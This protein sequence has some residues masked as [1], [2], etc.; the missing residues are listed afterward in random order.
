MQITSYYHDVLYCV[1]LIYKKNIFMPE[2]P[3]VETIAKELQNSSILNKIIKQV[4]VR[5]ASTIHSPSVGEF[6]KNLEGLKIISVKRR[7]K[8]IVLELSEGYF[9]IIHLR[10]TGRFILS[11]LIASSK[12]EHVILYFEGCA[13]LRYHD[14][15]KFGRFSLVK[16]AADILEELGPEP[17]QNDF[18][19]Q[20]FISM[21]KNKKSELKPLLL[22]QK[23]LAGLGNIYVDEAL[24]RASLHPKRQANTLSPED[25][26]TLHAAIQFVLKRGLLSNGTTL[27][28][29]KTNYYRID[30]VKGEHQDALD[31]FRK[32]GEPC[33]RC[34]CSIERLL[35]AQR[36]THICP[37]CQK[38][39][40]S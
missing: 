26:A 22:N 13:P 18:T 14:T 34:G 25:A 36:S 40:I 9:L 11:P 32:T 29:G 16:N 24:W 33:P 20:K 30:N 6:I 27:G 1:Y 38:K 21:L 23:F 37:A 15:R 2:L 4:D 8:Y 31:V 35:V 10:M 39:A 3:E 17:L 19:I 28:K 5:N 12:H 7:A